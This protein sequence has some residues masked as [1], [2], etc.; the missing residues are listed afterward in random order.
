MTK[1]CIFLLLVHAGVN[2]E[3]GAKADENKSKRRSF[4]FS[5]G[6]CLWLRSGS[7]TSIEAV[8]HLGDDIGKATGVWVGAE[9]LG[10]PCI[11]M[12]RGD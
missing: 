6:G 7:R 4:R 9:D 10:H 2:D 5:T 3:A 11:E 8:A 1:N 12:Y